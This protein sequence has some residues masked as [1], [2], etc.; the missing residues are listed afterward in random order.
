MRERGTER[1]KQDEIGKER[2][3]MEQG[4]VKRLKETGA[5]KEKR[6]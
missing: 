2:M 5:G 6:N 3:K 4:M 1:E